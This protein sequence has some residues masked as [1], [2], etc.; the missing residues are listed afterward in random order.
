MITTLPKLTAFAENRAAF[1]SYAH[2]LHDS[3]SEALKAIDER[4]L[5]ALVLAGENIDTACEQ[6]HRVYWYPNTQEPL[7]SREAPPP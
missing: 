6:C 7:N 2:I 1:I 5:D 3:G 4:N